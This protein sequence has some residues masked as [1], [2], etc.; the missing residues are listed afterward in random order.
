MSVIET[1]SA[2]LVVV[3]D[4]HT[5]SFSGLVPPVIYRSN[6]SPE[7]ANKFQ[8]WLWNR[9]LEFWE[10]IEE[11]KERAGLP[12]IFVVNGD[13][14]DTNRHAPH[15]LIDLDPNVILNTAIEV[16]EPPM[17]LADRWYIVRG[18]PSHTG[19]NCWLEERLAKELAQKPSS[20]NGARPQARTGAENTW[21][22]SWWKVYL[23]VGGVTFDIMHRPESTSLRTWTLGGGAMRIAKTVVDKYQKTKNTPPDVALRNHFHHWE[24][25]GT[26][27][28]TRAFILPAWQGPSSYTMGRGIDPEGHEYGG[29]YFTCRDG[30]YRPFEPIVYMQKRREPERFIV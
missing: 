1:L 10:Y 8:T 9:W 21:I 22:Y 25:S 26:N 18:T 19:R 15:E 23:E 4:L 16:L 7:Y 11:L 20:R 30:V 13:S 2:I 27:F 6:G 29:I 3:G 28:A 5:N 17:E 14:V 24:D 12:L